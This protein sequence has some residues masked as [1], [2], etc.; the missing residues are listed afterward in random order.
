MSKGINSKKFPGV[1][2]LNY[3]LFV[4]KK[5]S[6]LHFTWATLWQM[7]GISSTVPA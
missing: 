3:Q 1:F 4:N 5:G 2:L 6:P 7:F